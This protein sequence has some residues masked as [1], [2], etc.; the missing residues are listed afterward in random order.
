MST[1]V[2]VFADWE[3]FEEPALVGTLR[4]CTA[5]HKEHFSFSYDT[6]LVALS[7]GQNTIVSPAQFVT[8]CVTFWEGL[9]KKVAYSADLRHQN[10]CRTPQSTVLPR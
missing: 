6:C 8:Q 1:E 9:V 4:S 2:F 3:E 10:L 5:R 7:P